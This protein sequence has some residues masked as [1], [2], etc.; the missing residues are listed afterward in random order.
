VEF[1]VLPIFSPVN[2]FYHTLRN[3]EYSFFSVPYFILLF[4]AYNDK[5]KGRGGFLPRPA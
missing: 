5:A 2:F 3:K 4:C 1:I